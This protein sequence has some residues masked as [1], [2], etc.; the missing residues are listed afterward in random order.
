MFLWETINATNLN[1]DGWNVSNF[2]QKYKDVLNILS[3]IYIKSWCQG[4][5]TSFKKN[6]NLHDLKICIHRYELLVPNQQE[7]RCRSFSSS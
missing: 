7:F 3:S 5:K 1:E 6:Y 4:L 2:L